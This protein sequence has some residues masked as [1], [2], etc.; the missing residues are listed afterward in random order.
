MDGDA[1]G[2]VTDSFY[3]AYQGGTYAV[4]VSDSF[5]SCHAI[6]N[7]ELIT[8]ISYLINE[9]IRIYPNPASEEFTIYGLRFTNDEV[10]NIYDVLGEVLAVQSPELI[11]TGETKTL[12]KVSGQAPSEMRMDV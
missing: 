9:G 10:V 3:V 8:S 7:G 12:P 11:G 1:I 6:S 2:G 4:Q 5:G